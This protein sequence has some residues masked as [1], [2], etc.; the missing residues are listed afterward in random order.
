M[1]VKKTTVKP[2]KKCR[3]LEEIPGR[4]F[5]DTNVLNFILHYGEQIHD[6]AE[7]PTDTSDRVRDDIDAL[8]NIFLT[9]R[10]ASWQLA[11]SPYTYS[12]LIRTRAFAH[13][14][15]L[16]LWF[17]DL[18]ASWISIIHENDDLPSFIEGEDTRV[19][20][21]S[22]PAFNCLP[23]ISDRALICDAIVYRCELFCTRDWSTILKH[24]S[25]LK[26]LPIEIVTPA[27]WWA[28]IR[29]HSALWM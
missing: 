20:L 14:R 23:D 13:R 25:K 12:E 26:E 4:V 21:L 16:T 3:E 19:H 17:E 24:R 1:R 2:K 9:G 11:I 29:P 28:K 27:E 6:G 15:Q 8:Y 5:L 22:S 18:S 10:R 7:P